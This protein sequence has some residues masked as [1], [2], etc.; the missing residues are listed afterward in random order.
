MPKFGEY[1]WYK[2]EH[3]T[4]PLAPLFGQPEPLVQFVAGPV[5]VSEES[6]I[7]FSGTSVFQN[8]ADAIAYCMQ[9][10]KAWGKV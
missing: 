1:V 8:E 3:E 2:H 6:E 4:N 9:K 10:N 7:T 5:E